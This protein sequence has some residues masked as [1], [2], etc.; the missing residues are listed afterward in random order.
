VVST[1]EAEVAAGFYQAAWPQGVLPAA[2]EN[3][4]SINFNF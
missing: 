3:L 2:A 4:Y 1:T